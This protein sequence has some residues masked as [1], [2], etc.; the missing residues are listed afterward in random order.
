MLYIQE[1]STFFCL[2][3]NEKYKVG[4][5]VA[6]A[7]EYIYLGQRLREGVAKLLFHG[8]PE[9]VSKSFAEH[10]GEVPKRMTLDEREK[11]MSLRLVSGTGWNVR[12]LNGILDGDDFLETWFQGFAE[13]EDLCLHTAQSFRG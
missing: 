8:S 2:D 11:F 12:D 10:M 7:F 13:Q 3:V 1:E 6:V 9:E 4:E 5:S